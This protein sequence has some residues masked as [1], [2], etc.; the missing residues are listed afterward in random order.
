MKRFYA[1]I[2]LTIV[3]SCI[4]L[5]SKAQDIITRRDNTTIKAKIVAVEENLIS[6]RRW[7]NQ[8]GPLYKISKASV[9]KIKYQNGK[10]ETF[11][12]KKADTPAS[13]PEPAAAPA[14][15]T[16]EPAAPA[17]SPAK[18]APETKPAPP[19]PA[20]GKLTYA[21]GQFS[22]DGE[23]L[24]PSQV[25]RLIGDEIYHQ[26]YESAIKQRKT[27]KA[28][29]IIGGLITGAGAV[30]AG[31]GIALAKETITE[32]YYQD[33]DDPTNIWDVTYS[34][35]SNVDVMLPLQYAGFIA[36]GVGVTFLSF[37]IPISVIGN[38]RLGWIAS[39]YNNRSKYS[40]VFTVQPAPCGLRLALTF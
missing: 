1:L 18:P 10:E 24:T 7:D 31:V 3:L 37:G 13:S 17:A 26:T 15:K 34:T 2:V 39:D 8:N 14:P 22:L 27:G 4:P 23:V 5:V 36:M 30:A 11:L 33:I 19:A 35:E 29:N 16:Q 6:Y 28:L 40:A 20:D 38:K 21:K 25:R 12:G 32:T 9:R